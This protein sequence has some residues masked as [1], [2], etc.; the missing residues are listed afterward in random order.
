MEIALE[1]SLGLDIKFL[2]NR[3]D[4]QIGIDTVPQ[5]LYG[6]RPCGDYGAIWALD[7]CS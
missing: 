3:K 2:R 5:A 4:S 7:R 1:K 6:S